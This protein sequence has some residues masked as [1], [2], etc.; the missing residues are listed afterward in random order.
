MSITAKNSN[1]NVHLF[2]FSVCKGKT[3]AFHAIL[4]KNLN[5]LPRDTIIKFK[6]V[7]LNEGNGYN[8][9]TGK[10]TAPENGVYSFSWTYGTTRGGNVGIEG[11]VDGDCKAQI[12]TTGQ[13]GNFKNTSGHLVIKLKK[14]NQFWVQSSHYTANLIHERF[15]FLS[16][17]KINGC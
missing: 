5:N 1:M 16:G 8:P 7:K 15:T 2:S 10:F 4:S 6:N 12:A 17:Y 9:V 13:T 11:Y 3:I 14:G